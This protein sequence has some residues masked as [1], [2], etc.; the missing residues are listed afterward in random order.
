MLMNSITVGTPNLKRQKALE[1]CLLCHII[2]SVFPPLCG[3]HAGLT[4]HWPKEHDLSDVLA[5]KLACCS[6]ED[7]SHKNKNKRGR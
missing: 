1:N 6:Q 7:S 5:S 4:D 3:R 2:H